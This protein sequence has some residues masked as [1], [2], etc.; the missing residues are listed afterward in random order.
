LQAGKIRIGTRGSPLALAQAREVVARLTK[1]HKLAEGACE[2][3]V[4]K[5]SGDRITDRPLGEEG[6]KGLF[7]KEIEEALLEGSI[8]LAVHSMKDMV[9][10]LPTG[11]T[12]GAALKR[13]DPRDA[14]VSLKYSSFAEVPEGAVIGTSS[15]RRQA[16]LLHRRPDLKIVPLR[17]NVETRLKKLADGQASAT[18]LAC[19]GLNRL[20]LAEHIREPVS[21]DIMLPAVA[22][23]AIA[24]EVRAD[25]AE[26]ALLIAPLNDGPTALCVGAERAFL[27]KLDGSCRTPIAGLAELRD[28]V[29]RF[30]GEILTPDGKQRLATERSGSAATALR[31]GE[32]A[33][34]EL[35]DRAGPDFLRVLA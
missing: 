1:A 24:I 19:A 7:T 35:L 17:G 8:D 33:A 34:A 25:D 29:I 14:F 11:L 26:T 9:T 23:G 10:V 15:L 5:T 21:T 30:R 13:E 2:V 4:I 28:N 6:G 22:Q 32:D 12:L 18:F 16:Q 31:L 3:V 20:G 27:A